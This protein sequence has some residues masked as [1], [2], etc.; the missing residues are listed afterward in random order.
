MWYVFYTKD[1][2]E[3]E[4]DTGTLPD[5]IVFAVANDILTK[6]PDDYNLTDALEK[7]PTLYEESMNTVL[8]QEMGRFNKL[9]QT[10]RNSVVN[11]QRA[12]K[13]IRCYVR[14]STTLSWYREIDLR[15]SD[16]EPGP[17]RGIYVDNDRKDTGN[18]DEKFLSLVETT[19]QLY[20]RFLEKIDFPPGFIVCIQFYM[21]IYIYINIHLPTTIIYNDVNC[22]FRSTNVDLVRGRC[23]NNVL[24]IWILLHPSISY[25]CST[26]LF[27]KVQDS[28]RF[29]N[30]RFRTIERNDIRRTSWR[31]GL[32]LRILSRWG[33][34]Q[35]DDYEIRRI[36]AK[37]FIR[38]CTLRKWSRSLKSAKNVIEMIYTI[39]IML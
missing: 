5:D 24:D 29:V 23:A 39:R 38:K 33:S 17:R 27:E 1:T 11:V 12:I 16:H 6:L 28:Y 18:M 3:T 21:H 31:W 22:F 8:V 10:I 19:W 20:S 7:Y 25:R 13:G 26:K 35:Y 15:S 36:L 30:I 34:F 37:N 9:L 14:A 2:A 32:R 4:V